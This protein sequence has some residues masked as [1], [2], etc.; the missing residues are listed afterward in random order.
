VTALA[1]FASATG[2]SSANEAVDSRSD[3]R[4][5]VPHQSGTYVPEIVF[6]ESARPPGPSAFNR[7]IAE[8]K[9]MILAP[10]EPQTVL[11]RLYVP[12][13][14]GPFPAVVLL[15]GS[16]GVWE[17]NDMWAERLR[18]W[19]YVVLDV[20]SNTP[21]G[22]YRHNTG[23]G[24]SQNGRAK[25]LAGAFAQ[26]LDARGAR[27]HLAALDFVD[28]RRIAAFGM[29]QGGSAAMYA[30]AR[31]E[32]PNLTGAFRAAVAFYP[33]CHKLPGFEAPL[34]VLIGTAD[35]WVSAKHCEANLGAIPKTHEIVLK[36]YHG[37]HHV[38]DF[39]APER[40]FWGFL[41]R[42]DATAAKDA[43]SRIRTFLSKHLD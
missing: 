16:D 21:R 6:F 42:Y 2:L 35:E 43:E 12:E 34:M 18:A 23:I 24:I 28:P 13:S 41:L 5:A 40:R 33:A 17:W 19:G 4:Q 10:T 8:K 11:G 36:I 20:D 39:D 3:S 37:V 27:S 31:D 14:A 7:R 29:S 30:I 38:F 25:R 15:H 32:N 9:G 22:L 26:S 1:F